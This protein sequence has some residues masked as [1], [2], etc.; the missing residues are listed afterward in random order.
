MLSTKEHQGCLTAYATCV[1]QR[2]EFT[3]TSINTAS[4]FYQALTTIQKSSI[5][6]CKH[7]FPSGNVKMQSLLLWGDYSLDVSYYLCVVQ[8]FLLLSKSFFFFFLG[9]IWNY[10][11]N[12]WGQHCIISDVLTDTLTGINNSI[13][14][15]R[16]IPFLHFKINQCVFVVS[17]G[18]K[19]IMHTEIRIF[20]A[21]LQLQYTGEMQTYK[22]M[23]KW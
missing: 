1:S 17:S 12:R 6:F 23:W 16:F 14:V 5:K 15:L 9:F 13:F 18:C 21:L 11:Y 3:H 20:Y 22:E 8:M 2:L 4:T 7:K 19:T 10:K